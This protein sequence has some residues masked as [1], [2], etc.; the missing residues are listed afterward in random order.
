MEDNRCVCCG[1]IIPEGR[2]LCPEC[3]TTGHPAAAIKK[4]IKEYFEEEKMTKAK[5]YCAYEALIEVYKSAKSTRAD[6]EMAIEEAIGY[7]GEV[8]V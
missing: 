1:V 8:L 3:E 5:V 2:M 7:L 6:F 4:A